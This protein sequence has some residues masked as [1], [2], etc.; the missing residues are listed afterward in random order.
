MVSIDRR[1]LAAVKLWDALARGVIT[2]GGVT[3]I[4]SVIL[5]LVLIVWVTVPLFQGAASE[6]RA[7]IP[8]PSEVSPDN[9]IAA[10]VDLV[11]LGDGRHADALSGY[12]VNDCGT[13]TFL[14]FTDADG[15]GRAASVGSLGAARILGE[16]KAPPPGG[17]ADAK[18]SGIHPAG[19]SRYTLLWDDGSATLVEAVL[20]GQFDQQGRRGIEHRLKVHGEVEPLQDGAA[21][22]AV[23]RSVSGGIACARRTDDNRI[24]MTR[25]IA[26]SR[27]LLGGNKI[28]R[29]QLAISDGIPGQ[30]TSLA[31]NRAGDALYAGTENGHLLVFRL[32]GQGNL[33][34]RETVAAFSDGRSVTALGMVFGD[35]SLAVG[36][37]EGLVSTWSEVRGDESRALT[38]IH[39]LARHRGPVTAI[40]PSQRDQTL[41]SLGEGGDAHLDYV[42]SEKHLLALG[43]D[44][45][46]QLAGYAERGNA[47]IA[48]D[49]EGRLRVWQVAPRHP[50][51]SWRTL[52]GKVW[53]DNHESP[54]YIWQSSGTDEPKFSLVPIIFGTLKATV[55]AML[56]AAPLGLLG[57]MYVSH[58]TTPAFRKVIKPMVEVMAA[59][60]SVVI[61]FLILLWLAPLLNN[62]IVAV[63]V[64]FVTLPVCFV[65]FMLAW[66]WLRSFDWAKRMENGYEFIV[67][68]PVVVVGAGLAIWSEP[69]VTQALFGGSF[70]QWL[71]D[72]TGN[73]YDPLNSL[74]VAFGLGYAVIPIV[75]SLSEDSLSAI[76][77]ELTA[78][79]L[80]LGAS[81]W[82]TVSRVILPSASPAIF[83]AMMIGFGRAVGETMIVFMATGN[84][85]ILDWSPFNGFR[86]LSANIAVEIPEAARG[87]TLYRILFLCAVILF[88]L[89]FLLNT[90]A[91]VVR[92]RLRRKY[93][94]Y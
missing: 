32:D 14:E 4:A 72:S 29:K 55:Y 8:M 45:P 5:I 70:Q 81:R 28:E 33:A 92:Q 1:R 48:S 51:V 24:V 20:A 44:R 80:A 50:E 34:S 56:F 41:M 61:G 68:I 43:D 12:L 59:V 47:I 93:G 91:E 13:F 83:A 7:D 25:D 53:Y 46:L 26:V 62:W 63:F 21:T 39:E 77:H 60:P 74:V 88:G 10:G 89:T 85:P 23:M 76:P 15:G 37:S 64:S 78:A 84:T 36:D 94:R 71:F 86:T 18:I 57:A 49:A 79:S 58:F 30:V 2:L 31:L 42:T 27:G 75:F 11:V 67:L 40:L 73:R 90:V 35:V 65:A 82:Q 87:E 66:Q 54:K 16:E 17:R 38:C 19:G 22:L 6:L 52:F 9:L 69:Y 3:I